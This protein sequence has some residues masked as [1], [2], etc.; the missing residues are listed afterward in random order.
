MTADTN[1]THR[2]DKSILE[3]VA[4]ILSFLLVMTS[5]TLPLLL[6]NR[7]NLGLLATLVCVAVMVLCLWFSRRLSRHFVQGWLIWMLFLFS[8]YVSIA[9]SGGNS[10][11]ATDGA[12]LCTARPFPTIDKAPCHLWESGDVL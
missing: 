1:Y 9:L 3:V 6:G 2:P 5:N 11:G 7:Q 4:F 10:G 12:R 8:V